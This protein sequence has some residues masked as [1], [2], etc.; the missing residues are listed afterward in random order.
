MLSA[1]EPLRRTR[2]PSKKRLDDEVDAIMVEI[3]EKEAELKSIGGRGEDS[4]KSIRAEK[5]ATFERRKKVDSDLKGLNQAITQK[6]NALSKLQSS[7]HYTTEEK[8]NDAIRK[9]EWNMKVQNFKLSQEK[10]IVAEIDSLKRSKKMLSSYLSMKK[11]ID[12][13]RDRQRRMREE[14][15]HYF[16][17]VNQLKAKEEDIRKKSS[18]NKSRA[19]VLKKEINELY[20]RKRSM[21]AEFRKQRDVFQDI[22]KK[23][24]AE[25][26]RRREEER[27]AL[28]EAQQKEIEEMEALKE[29]YE[30]EK[31]LC[32]TLIQYLHKI[33][34]SGDTTDAS[35]P[36]H[37]PD[38]AASS[39]Q[40]CAPAL[41][42]EDGYRLLRKSDEEEFPP[43]GRRSSKSRRR[44]RKLSMTKPVTHTP[45]VISQFSSLNLSAPSS[46]VEIPASLEHLQGR[47]LYYEQT[48]REVKSL[49]SDTSPDALLSDIASHHRC[50]TETWGFMGDEQPIVEELSQSEAGVSATESVVCEMSRQA[51][52]TESCES[53]TDTRPSDTLMEELLQTCCDGGCASK[54]KT[55]FQDIDSHSLSD[56]SDTPRS[57]STL[58]GSNGES[59]GSG[60]D[61]ER[62]LHS[63][64]LQAETQSHICMSNVGKP[65]TTTEHQP[66]DAGIS[67]CTNQPDCDKTTRSSDRTLTPVGAASAEESRQTDRERKTIKKCEG[68]G[69]IKTSDKKSRT[70]ANT[71][72]SNQTTK[73]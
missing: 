55:D 70:S 18:T 7:L 54:L 30:D 69:H 44:S 47:K 22:M 2:P 42:N 12:E 58:E 31:S 34:P 20:E 13:S 62:E 63:G 53:A 61:F 26:F 67:T 19:E 68:N 64:S 57:E 38:E 48:A 10:K 66:Q 27:R 73:M 4:L 65:L 29:P 50:R 46:L 21:V 16:R 51:S 3:R 49:N 59:M 14:R 37:A 43:L 17:T 45:H 8:H 71:S 39:S 9:L 33:G 72:L 40:A 23:Q 32:N 56:S 52:K 6:M 35:A 5:E 36:S 11:E 41:E 25:S 24:R 15:D 1:R 60:N 28:L